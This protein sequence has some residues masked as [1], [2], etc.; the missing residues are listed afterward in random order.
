MENWLCLVLLLHRLPPIEAESS[1]D[2]VITI[3]RLKCKTSI[4]NYFS[5]NGCANQSSSLQEPEFM[6]NMFQTLPFIYQEPEAGNL[7]EQCFSNN[8]D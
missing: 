2:W 3:S 7:R 1:S 4:K 5:C 8:M 6:T